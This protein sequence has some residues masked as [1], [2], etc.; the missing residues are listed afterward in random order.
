MGQQLKQS[1]YDAMNTLFGYGA[2][3]EKLG[4][5]SLD[6]G[7]RIGEAAG[8]AG[9]RQAQLISGQEDARVA[10]ENTPTLFENLIYG[11]LQAGIGAA[12]GGM[13]GS[14]GLRSNATWLPSWAQNTSTPWSNNWGNL[15]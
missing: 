1:P 7:L 10:A 5:G 15:P 12:T 4:M 14:G 9:A 3:T 6:A 13:G 2:N 11:G 8:N